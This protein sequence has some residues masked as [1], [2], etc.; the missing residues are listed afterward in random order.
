MKVHI[1]FLLLTSIKGNCPSI[2]PMAL[3]INV[4]I[5]RQNISSP[6]AAVTCTADVSGQ[7]IQKVSNRGFYMLSPYYIIINCIECIWQNNAVKL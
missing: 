7:H 2:Y 3:E 6:S 1:E 4:D 5:R